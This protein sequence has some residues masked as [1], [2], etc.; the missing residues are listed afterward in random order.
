VKPPRGKRLD[1][2]KLEREALRVPWRLRGPRPRAARSFSAP[3]SRVWGRG[4]RVPTLVACCACRRD[5]YGFPSRTSRPIG[6]RSCGPVWLF[7]CPF[8]PAPGR[9]GAGGQ[10]GWA[11]GPCGRGLGQ[12]TGVSPFVCCPIVVEW[13]ARASVAGA[14]WP[15]EPRRC[16]RS[17]GWG[18]GLISKG[19][20]AAGKA[21]LRVGPCVPVSWC[22]RGLRQ[23]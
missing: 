12:L 22:R 15:G 9:L 2:P 17:W 6:W 1:L 11:C 5:P 16:Q 21:C 7:P 13:L 23:W 18:R 14:I 4:L 10:A 8:T 3:P 20:P 19:V